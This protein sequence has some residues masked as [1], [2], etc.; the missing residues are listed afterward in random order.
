MYPPKQI[1]IHQKKGLEDVP[2]P[3]NPSKCSRVYRRMSMLKYELTHTTHEER[4]WFTVHAAAAVGQ[5]RT[6]LPSTQSTVTSDT[7]DCIHQLSKGD[8][9][10]RPDV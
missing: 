10:G 7:G 2:T 5:G 8:G 3:L 4:C 1:K 9:R 6:R